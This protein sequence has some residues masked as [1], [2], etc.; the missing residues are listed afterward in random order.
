[1][2]NLKKLNNH[3]F[4]EL[5]KN[6]QQEINNIYDVFFEYIKKNQTLLAN[7]NGS[8]S[9]LKVE[10]KRVF[11]NLLKEKLKL[12]ETLFSD[13]N[14]SP[15]FGKIYRTESTNSFYLLNIDYSFLEKYLV[16]IETENDRQNISFTKELKEMSENKY[17][18]MLNSSSVSTKTTFGALR[19]SLESYDLDYYG[20]DSDLSSV[21]IQSNLFYKYL[22]EKMIVNFINNIENINVDHFISE[23]IQSVI[24][25]NALNNDINTKINLDSY[26]N[27]LNCIQEKYMSAIKKK[28]IMTNKNSVV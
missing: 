2:I 13:K 22:N 6:D 25:L 7:K 28:A 11:L 3:L 19:L 27:L 15:Q 21:Y 18:Y 24:D 12:E 20:N 9:T 16:T 1:M 14:K 4:S 8:Y 26:K 23:N 5:N 17:K 10:Q